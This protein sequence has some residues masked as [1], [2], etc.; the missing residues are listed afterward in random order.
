MWIFRL[1]YLA[2]GR[3]VTLFFFAFSAQF[4][5]IN[6]FILLPDLI[7][8]FAHWPPN[9]ALTK[10]NKKIPRPV[11][12]WA[13]PRHSRSSHSRPCRPYGQRHTASSG[14]LGMHVA[15]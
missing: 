15:P 10:K 12:R 14:D 1:D 9:E 6:P 4:C 7:C 3:G 2:A 5:F 11:S 13:L 8:P